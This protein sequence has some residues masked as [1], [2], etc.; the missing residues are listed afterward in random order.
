MN[1]VREVRELLEEERAMVRAF[2]KRARDAQSTELAA[3]REAYKRRVGELE[4]EV[5]LAHS[6]AEGRADE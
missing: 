4:A 3:E 6:L 5:K 2:Q 1:R